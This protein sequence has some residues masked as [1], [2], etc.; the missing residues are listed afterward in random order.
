MGTPISTLMAGKQKH[1][2]K[3]LL[4]AYSSGAGSDPV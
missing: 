3:L 1:E 2:Q 4:T